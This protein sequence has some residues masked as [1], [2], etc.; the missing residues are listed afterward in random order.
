LYGFHHFFFGYFCIKPQGKDALRQFDANFEGVL[1]FCAGVLICWYS[2]H[3]R[4]KKKA[5]ILRKSG[6]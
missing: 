1:I 6:Y 2:I 4:T 3:S 5:E